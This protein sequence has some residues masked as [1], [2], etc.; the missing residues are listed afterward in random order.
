MM[1]SQWAGSFISGFIA[2]MIGA[3]IGFVLGI[4]KEWRSHRL[5]CPCRPCAEWRLIDKFKEILKKEKDEKEKNG[6][7]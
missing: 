3:L 7:N 5:I 2:G 1:I 4:W 6:T